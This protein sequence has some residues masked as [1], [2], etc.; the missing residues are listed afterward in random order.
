MALAEIFSAL[1]DPL[2]LEMVQ[3]LSSG[4]PCTINTVLSGLGNTRQGARKHLQAL[5]KAKIVILEP[6]G[7]ETLV[8][9]D[10]SALDQAKS[11][12]T[13]L[14]LQWDQRLDALRRFV[15]DDT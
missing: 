15:E 8:Q 7:R 3:R 9:L 6:K 11:Y 14:E 12:I 10:R 13:E 4:A 1:G 2:R 5:I